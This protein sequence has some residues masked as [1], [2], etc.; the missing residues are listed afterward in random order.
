MA[1]VAVLLLFAG[2]CDHSSSTSTRTVVVFTALDRIYSE[3]ILQAF[4][5]QSGIHV[6]PVD[7][8]ESAK[9]TGLVNRWIARREHPECDVLWNNG[10]LQTEGLPQQNLLDAYDSPAAQRFDA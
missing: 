2:A 6:E 9:R 7:D 8:G 1:I 3:P 4:E 10:I 5:K